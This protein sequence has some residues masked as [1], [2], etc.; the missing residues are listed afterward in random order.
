MDVGPDARVQAHEAGEKREDGDEGEVDVT[1]MRVAVEAVVDRREEGAANEDRDAGVV[2]E[3]E[4][5]AD[6]A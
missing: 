4:E 2:E 5:V 6:L 3:Q 1:E